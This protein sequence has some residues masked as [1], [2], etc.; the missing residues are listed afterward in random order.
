M[1]PCLTLQELVQFRTTGGKLKKCELS[2]HWPEEMTFIATASKRVT[3]EKM[4]AALACL[5]LKVR[6]IFGKTI[7][8]LCQRVRAVFT[9]VSCHLV[10]ELEL[11]DKNNNPLTHAKYNREEVREAGE[12]ERRP[13]PL[14]VPQY[15]EEHMREY[16]T[17]VSLHLM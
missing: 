7:L 5:K 16:L 10:Q 8:Y 6:I 4:A 15:L 2:L 11:L 17:Q 14:E 1:W 13:L 9:Y 3:A 12:R